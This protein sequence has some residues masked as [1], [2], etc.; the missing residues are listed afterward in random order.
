MRRLSSKTKRRR[1]GVAAVEA[2]LCLPVVLILMLGTLEICSGIFLRESLKIASFEG[3]R[4]GV[5]RQST[6]DQ[7]RTTVT[8]VLQA[9]GVQGAQIEIVPNSFDGL[10]ALSPIAVTVTAPAEGNSA[11]NLNFLTGRTVNARTT[12]LREFDE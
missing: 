6:P 11:F 2:A 4:A 10:D 3:A 9:R 12:M 8:E 7:V 5:R 1:Q